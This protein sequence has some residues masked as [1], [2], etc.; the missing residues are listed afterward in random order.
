MYRVVKM[1]TDIED[2]GHKYDEGDTFPREGL[3]VTKERLEIL[4]TSKNLQGVPLIEEI[5]EP[6]KE[7][8]QPKEPDTKNVKKETKTLTRGDKEEEGK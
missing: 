2:K 8:E 4:S 3:K 1:F 7:P 6:L 5:S